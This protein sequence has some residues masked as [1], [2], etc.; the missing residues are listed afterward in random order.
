M[1]FNVVHIPRFYAESIFRFYINKTVE[2]HDFFLL[3]KTKLK[4]TYLFL[5]KQWW[6]L[7]CSKTHTHTLDWIFRSQFSAYSQLYAHKIIACQLHARIILGFFTCTTIYNIKCY[8]VI[9]RSNLGNLDPNNSTTD[10]FC[11]YV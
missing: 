3:I 4:F 10:F 11:I 5:V 9:T 7:G 2:H 8:I 1:L 6:W